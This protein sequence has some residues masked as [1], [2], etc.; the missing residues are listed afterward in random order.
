[1]RPHLVREVMSQPAIT[2]AWD[3]S[4]LEASGLMESNNIRRLPVVDEDGLLVGIV[5]LGDVR[6]AM[7]VYQTANP[8]APDSDH[9]LL[10]VDEVM[11]TPAISVGPDAR[12]LDVVRLMLEHKIGGVPVVDEAGHPAG[13]VTESDLFR[14]MIDLWEQ[15]G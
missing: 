2:I 7:S 4:I 12:L 15:G 9:V 13:M 10:A 8:Y 3:R 5:S 14:L 1:M 6:E 11:T